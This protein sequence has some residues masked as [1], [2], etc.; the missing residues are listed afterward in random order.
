MNKKAFTL[1]ELLAVI[2]I[3]ALLAIIVI[4][5]IMDTVDESKQQ[6][7]DF[8]IQELENYSE[9][10]ATANNLLKDVTSSNDVTITLDD[11]INAS[12]MKYPVINPNTDRKLDIYETVIVLSLETDGDVKYTITLHEE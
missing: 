2:V 12:Y 10:Y 6:N 4:P 3:L 11:L 5:N 7:Y 8:L 1:I 9:E